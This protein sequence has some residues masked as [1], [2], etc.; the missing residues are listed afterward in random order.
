MAFAAQ[1]RWVWGVEG[2][3]WIDD[4][5]FTA[6]SLSAVCFGERRI[7]RNARRRDDRRP[8]L[9]LWD[10]GGHLASRTGALWS[11]FSFSAWRSV[12]LSFAV[13]GRG[14]G[15]F[16]CGCRPTLFLLLLLLLAFGGPYAL[17]FTT[18]GISSP[19]RAACAAKHGVADSRRACYARDIRRRG[20]RIQD[21]LE[22]RRL[23]AGLIRSGLLEEPNQAQRMQTREMRCGHTLGSLG[24]LFDDSV[25]VRG[26]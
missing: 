15:N 4:V 8:S 23:E 7:A 25:M 10:C 16:S 1:I 18:I 3:V 21:V 12:A 22:G 9:H 19:P 26:F 13:P 6:D 11:P 2:E 5:F 17:S 24:C 20:A 14:R